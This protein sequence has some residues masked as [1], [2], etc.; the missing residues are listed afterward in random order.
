MLAQNRVV[1]IGG[2]LNLAV[3]VGKRGQGMGVKVIKSKAIIF[4]FGICFGG[5]SYL[6]QCFL[7]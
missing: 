3:C 4:L 5:I 2:G 6:V 7:S 1:Q